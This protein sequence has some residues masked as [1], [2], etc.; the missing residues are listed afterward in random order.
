MPI[1]GSRC[2]TTEFKSKRSGCHCS[3]AE[4]SGRTDVIG[5]KLSPPVRS[6]VS[7]VSPTTDVDGDSI[8]MIVT[9]GGATQNE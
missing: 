9:C 8:P 2:M 7:A 5:F 3:C 4:D 6:T 1:T